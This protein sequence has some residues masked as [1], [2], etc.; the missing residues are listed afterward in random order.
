MDDFPAMSRDGRR[1][2]YTE[3]TFQSN[4]WRRELSADGDV[5]PPGRVLSS[6]GI[7][8]NGQ[9]SPN[10]EEIV[11]V[12]TR[13]GNHEIWVSRADGSAA[14]QLTS[15]PGALSMLPRWSPSGERIAFTSNTDGGRAVYVMDAGGGAPKRLASA[16]NLL[17]TWSADG[18]WIYY[19]DRS[20]LYKTPSGGGDS[21]LVVEDSSGG[22]E[23][24]DGKTLYYVKPEAGYRSLWRRSLPDGKDTR[25]AGGLLYSFA[26]AVVE[27]GV[28]FA[29]RP[30]PGKPSTVAF[31]SF[32]TEDVETVFEY[33]N[34]PAF[35]LSVAPDGRSILYSLFDDSQADI[36]LV[37]DFQ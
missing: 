24:A 33:E 15:F 9:Y 31:Y 1:L 23:S 2:A 35:G 8:G 11:F 30:L 10:L 12:S 21:H 36:M 28:Y 19:G 5:G 17:A 22:V 18:E 27:H 20:G 13:T 3:M 4:I 14:Q 32:A 7:D 25:L 26:F 29:L 16:G 6:T 34:K 37:E